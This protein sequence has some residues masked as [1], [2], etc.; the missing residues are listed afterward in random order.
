MLKT[1]IISI[2]GN[3]G[4]LGIGIGIK[5]LISLLKQKIGDK[6]YNALVAKARLVVEDL[7]K[8][9]ADSGANV[10][11]ET[12]EKIAI[13][14]VATAT[15]LNAD[16]LIEIVHSIVNEAEVA[17]TQETPQDVNDETVASSTTQPNTTVQ[18]N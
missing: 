16:E 4:V 9:F 1:V 10:E 17:I 7:K 2:I 15:G 6:K 18:Q 5:L 8:T 3:Y 14:K 12:F 13:D 11:L